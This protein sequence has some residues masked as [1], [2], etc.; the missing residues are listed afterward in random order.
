MNLRADFLVELGTEELPPKS[1]RTLEEAFRDGLLSRIDAAGLVHGAVES[2]S[3]PRRLAVRVKRLALQATDQQLQRRGPPLS[4]ALDASGQPTRAAQAFAQSCGVAF[5][6]LGREKDPK[7]NEALSFTGVKPGAAARE[8]LP[9][10]VSE[11]LDALPI[12][13]RMRWGAGDAQFVRPVHWLVLLHGAEVIPATVL[14]ASSGNETRGHRFHSSKALR[15][16]SPASYETTLEKRG[17]VIANFARRRATIRTGVESIATGLGGT[18]LISDAL[19]DEVTALVEWP[20]PLAGRFEDRFLTLPR[21]LLVS[22]LQDHQR[23]FPV[24]AADASLLPWFITVSNIES[25]D[26]AVVRAGNERVVRPRLADAA[27]FWEQD[28]KSPLAARLPQLDAVTFQAQLG[29][30]GDKVRRIEHLA[31]EIAA[32]IDGDEKLAAR[33]AQLAKCDLVTNLVGEFP[34]LQGVMGRYLAQADGEPQEVCTAIDEH[35]Q[36]RGAGDTLPNTHSGLAVSI[37]DKLDTLTGVFAIGQKPSGTRDPFALRRA[38]IGIGRMI[39][40]RRLPLDLIDLID[41]S[42]R[43]HTVFEVPVTAGGKPLPSRAEVAAQVYDYMMERQRNAWLEPP[44]GGPP[45]PGITSEACDAV[46]AMRPRSPLDFDARVRALLTFLALPEATSLIAANKR[47]GNLLKKS[48]GAETASGQVDPMLIKSDVE[49][50]LYQSVLAA[51]HSVPGH[52]AV[53]AYAQALSEL[54]WLRKPVDAFFDQVMV[55]DPDPALRAN[56]LALLTQLRGLFMGIADLS[57][58]PG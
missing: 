17:K 10:L 54:A 35:Y 12:P 28:R 9:Q 13:K 45:I 36:P 29:S 4:A 57:R 48:A 46:L 2:F 15:I 41:E 42:L 20:V 30:I 18:A 25:T 32:R 37:A 53:G 24:A 6:E 3:T 1:L 7:G 40:E 31:R 52:I 33:A 14:G 44:D 51:E 27:F 55:M 16:S 43:T 8:L 11:A 19:L 22:V 50:D 47:I 5:A 39:Y 34:E 23:Y 58:L 56:R 21:E 49:R 38:A 26:P